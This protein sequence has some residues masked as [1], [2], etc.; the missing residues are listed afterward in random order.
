MLDVL[1]LL[2]HW[3]FKSKRPVRWLQFEV[4]VVM[5]SPL[6]ISGCWVP[7]PS[8]GQKAFRKLPT[9]FT[10]RTAS[11]ASKY[12]EALPSSSFKNGALACGSG[13]YADEQSAFAE[14]RRLSEPEPEP[15]PR[16]E[17]R[18]DSMRCL[19]DVCVV[20]CSPRP[21]LRFEA[22]AGQTGRAPRAG[23]CLRNEGTYDVCHIM[24]HRAF[25]CTSRSSAPQQVRLLAT[26]TTRGG[27]SHE[28]ERDENHSP[29]TPPGFHSFVRNCR[30]ECNARSRSTAR[31]GSERQRWSEP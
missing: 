7:A 3:R 28:P 18:C 25:P 5:R 21:W 14:P 2:R 15:E 30:G 16:A 27:M 19:R 8:C 12:C 17:Q 26:S 11:S 1:T 20:V 6:P 22:A 13:G 29:R 9:A 4:L 24:P 23:E 31:K 10:M